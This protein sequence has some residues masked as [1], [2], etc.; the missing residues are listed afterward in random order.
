MQAI[1]TKF[2]GPTNHR[3]PRVKAS[4]EAGSIIV[5]W[6]DALDSDGNHDAACR[7]LALKL[8]WFGTWLGGGLPDTTGNAYVCARRSRTWDGEA[9][10]VDVVR[11]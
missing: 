7:A 1:L 2:L 11:P 8:S 5:S 6:D 9:S 10:N 3:G 4:C